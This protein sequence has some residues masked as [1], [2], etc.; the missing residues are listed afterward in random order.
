[1][2]YVEPG[3]SEPGTEIAVN[4]RGQ[5]LLVTVTTLPFYSRKKE[6]S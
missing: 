3:Y 2:A 1:M 4:V 6:S 5:S